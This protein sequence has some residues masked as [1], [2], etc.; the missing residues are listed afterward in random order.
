MAVFAFSA[1]AAYAGNTAA[2]D[3]YSAE[4]HGTG[5]FNAVANPNGVVT[6]DSVENSADRAKK[7][8]AAGGKDGKS[9]SGGQ[10]VAAGPGGGSGAGSAGGGGSAGFVDSVFKG[11][12]GL[13]AGAILLFAGAGAAFTMSRQSRPRRP[14]R[15]KLTANPF[16]EGEP[17]P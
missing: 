8:A 4:P 14:R 11:K 10:P 16:P 1:T 15:P 9:G 7:Q 2:L 6:Q 3:Q 17:L 12:N 5:N 13:A